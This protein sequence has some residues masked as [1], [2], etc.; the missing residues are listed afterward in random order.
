MGYP[1]TNSDDA[2][3]MKLNEV[4]IPIW[5]TSFSLARDI[6]DSITALTKVN[7]YIYAFL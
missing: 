1:N 2:F 3:L 5:Y 7:G 4:A 6:P